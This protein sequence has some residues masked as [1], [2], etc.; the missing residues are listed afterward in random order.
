M[1]PAGA[2][3]GWAPAHAPQGAAG[4]IAELGEIARAEV[5]Q[6]VVFPVAPYVFDRIEFRRV[7][8]QALDGEPAPLRADEL[9]DQPRPM[10]RQPVPDHQE[11]ARQAA[12]QMAEE[13]DDLR[14][15]DGAG[16]EPEVEVPPGA[17]VRSIR[18]RR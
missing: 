3:Q 1:P 14:R 2:R 8:W 16:I 18:F 6:F 17:A 7:G 5:G 9:R 13:V 11:L 4:L 12:Q 10:L 15:T